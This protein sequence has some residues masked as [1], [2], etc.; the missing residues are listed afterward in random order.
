MDSYFI[1][2]HKPVGPTSQQC[3][4]QFKKTLPRGTKVGHHGTLDPFAEGLLL[5]AV[6]EAC[7][8]ISYVDD[9]KKTYEATLKLGQKTDTGD[10]TGKIIAKADLPDLSDSKIKDVLGS[11]V[12]R[13]SQIPPMHSAVKIDGVPLYKLAH[14]GQTIE[15][16][17]REVEIFALE[18]LSHTHEQ[19]VFL[20]NCS[21]GTYIRTLGETIAE[22]LGTVGH[23]QKLVRTQVVGQTLA[24]IN[25]PMP[26]WELLAHHSRIDLDAT[27]KILLYQGKRLPW[28]NSNEGLQAIFCQDEF[29][30]MGEV[31]LGELR[32]L[33][34]IA[35][36]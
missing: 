3:L 8:F 32:S 31:S 1:L 4:T 30:G 23:L 25:Q 21:R 36:V 20:A 19:I 10:L 28:S 12:G 6:N 35:L 22:K 27:Q 24:K 7:K 16:K 26:I 2:L 33:R 13:L 18:L 14:A 29:L 15:R 17:P 11:L 34:L 5:V 9:S